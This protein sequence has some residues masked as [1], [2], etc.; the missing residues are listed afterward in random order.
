MSRGSGG[1]RERDR[2]FLYNSAKR[3][4]I[5]IIQTGPGLSR[6]V[7][8]DSFA[9]LAP[10]IFIRTPLAARAFSSQRAI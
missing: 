6:R 4:V 7:C 3:A 1:S 2:Y 9:A 5:P 10:D 8:Q